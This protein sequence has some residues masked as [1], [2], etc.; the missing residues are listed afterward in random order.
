[1]YLE[2][3]LP[4]RSMDPETAVTYMC[5]HF[6]QVVLQCG[7]LNCTSVTQYGNSFGYILGI[8]PLLFPP[9][10]LLHY[11]PIQQHTYSN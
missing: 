10:P 9:Y 7:P 8:L 4:T 3:L 6:D 2:F 1:V 11:M 5:D